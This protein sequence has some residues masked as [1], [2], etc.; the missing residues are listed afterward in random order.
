MSDNVIQPSYALIDAV[1][2]LDRVLWEEEDDAGVYL[3]HS[4]RYVM[5]VASGKRSKKALEAFYDKMTGGSK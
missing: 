3:I 1:G 4:R 2:E 5:V